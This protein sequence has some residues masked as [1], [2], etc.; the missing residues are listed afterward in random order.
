MKTKEKQL[1]TLTAKYMKRWRLIAVKLLT[2][3]N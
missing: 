3:Q 2:A 1:V